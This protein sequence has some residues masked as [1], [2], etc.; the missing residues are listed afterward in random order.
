MAISKKQIID[1]LD[2]RIKNLKKELRLDL[3]ND[4]TSLNFSSMKNI[5]SYVR[6]KLGLS[7]KTQM[8]CIRYWRARGWNSD[9]SYIK[10]KQ[11]PRACE[12]ISPF[13]RKF[14]IMK[15]NPET[16]N[17]YTESE[18]DFQRNSM[19]PIRKEYWIKQ[20]Y[21]NIESIELAKETKHKN[22][23]AGSIASRSDES[24]RKHRIMSSTTQE[25]YDLRGYTS[26]EK[27]KALNTR[28]TT[29]TKAIC[30]ERYGEEDGLN[31]WNDRQAQWLNAFK[32]SG[33][34]NGFSKSSDAFFRK[35]SESVHN[36]Q[37]S[38]NEIVLTI[39]GQSIAVDCMRS[40]GRNIIEYHGDYWH[41]NP[42][43]FKNTDMI[44]SKKV[45]DIWES[46]ARRRTI[47]NENGYTVLTVWES[48]VK[49][50][51]EKEIIRCINFLTAPNEK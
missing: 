11:N 49:I 43:K 2:N 45:Q 40:G 27:E 34:H 18:S 28:Q 7:I 16:G 3:I 10:A 13:S 48:N 41:A 32:K 17:N 47:L 50:N 12:E 42:N 5:E 46:D 26:Y 36:L 35:L 25:Y 22:N 9:E 30:V 31:R 51:Q 37:Y 44:R 21:S 8:R 6:G 38:K 19:R 23:L 1:V 20:G 39:N 4:I 29:F 15:I 24:K 14:W 33:V